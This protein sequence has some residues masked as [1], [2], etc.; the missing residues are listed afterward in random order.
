MY[1]LAPGP[2]AVSYHITGRKTIILGSP[3]MVVV[4]YVNICCV[5]MYSCMQTST[6]GAHYAFPTPQNSIPKFSRRCLLFPQIIPKILECMSQFK[7]TV[8][9][10]TQH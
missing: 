6:G 10:Q 5:Y 7:S 3:L 8:H 2:R 1:S 9:T 4:V